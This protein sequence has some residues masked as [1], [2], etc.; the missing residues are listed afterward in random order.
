M[1]N[2]FLLPASLF[3]SLIPVSRILADIAPDISKLT[4]FGSWGAAT[5]IIIMLNKQNSDL[6]AQ[7]KELMNQLIN[8]CPSCDLARAAN[9]SLLDDDDKK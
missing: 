9:K 3:A 6:R 8:K 1:M 7:N 2:V 5:W 4:E